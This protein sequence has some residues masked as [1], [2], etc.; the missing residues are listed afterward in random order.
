MPIFNH[1]A[2]CLLFTLFATLP[3]TFDPAADLSFPME[4]KKGRQ[5]SGADLSF[6]LLS[7]TGAVNWMP[8]EALSFEWTALE[9][10]AGAYRIKI[11]EQAP[12]EPAP[13]EVPDT[14]LFF[15]QSG[16]SDTSFIYPAGGAPFSSGS[17]YAWQVET[18][19]LVDG[20]FRKSEN[21]G[22]I[23]FPLS[24]DFT[25]SGIPADTLC[26]GDCFALTAQFG[27]LALEHRVVLYAGHENLAAI[28]VQPAA[29][30]PFP[31]PE[32]DSAPLE[33]PPHYA[34]PASSVSFNI[35]INEGAEGPVH[36]SAYYYQPGFICNINPMDSQCCHDVES[37]EVQ[38]AGIPDLTGLQLEI[39][40]L[41]TG[42]PVA[43]ICSGDPVL[44]SIL[45][46]PTTENTSLVW[47]YNDGN[48]LVWQDIAAAPFSDYTFPAPPGHEVLSIDCEGNTEGFVERAFRAK[49]TF[50]D[51]P[52]FCE[53]YTTEYLLRICCP[54]TNASVEITTEDG[55]D[56]AV[57]L[58]EGD[59]LS[60]DVELLPEDL[61]VSPPGEFV[62]I[63]W[64]LNEVELPDQGGLAAFVLPITA[65]AAGDICLKAVVRNCAGKEKAFTRC[66]NVDPQPVCDT[67]IL[68]APT[69]EPSA[70]EPGLVVYEACPNSAF[71]L[72]ALGFDQSS[73]LMQWEY[74]YD[75]QDWLPL[76]S[77]NAIQNTNLIIEGDFTSIFYRV[78]CDPLS[79]PSGCESCFSSNI[80]EIRE[81][82]PPAEPAFIDCYPLQWCAGDVVAPYVT[83]VEPGVTYTWY[84]NGLALQ[85]NPLILEY[86]LQGNTCFQYTASNE[87][88]TVS[89]NSCCLEV[90][91]ITAAISCPLPPNECACLGDP[92]TL[93]AAG[94]PSGCGGGPLS[95]HWMW[96]DANG[97]PQTANTLSITDIPPANGTTYTLA[98]TD[99]E[100]GCSDT[101]SLSIIPCDKQ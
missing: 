40:S 59:A 65:A 92:I 27:G 15:E 57:G 85:E 20:Q 41:I 50:D 48:S 3:F 18:A 2:L 68:R 62:S 45:N 84:V 44:F 67:I 39:Q 69:L 76:G 36:F 22:V 61:F 82:Q 86:T 101:A 17:Q 13:D 64:F 16:V 49:L 8:G 66:I 24:C 47:Q 38:V 21:V 98:V 83:A 71:T 34:G 58:C 29:G 11:I 14:G 42:I 4:E 54:I 80:I 81:I 1:L 55:F 96:T 46:L 77:S 89:S 33:S 73:C 37:F 5:L 74:S 32:L 12:G 23:S 56:L 94:P 78:K 35:C 60:L 100:L 7:P 79:L 72:E 9:G 25:L 30:P 31:L 70:A 87:C 93:A 43:E 28:T 63:Q 91:E 75:E 51:A 10:Y 26:P 53:Y 88:H 19:E 6:H 90:C 95:Y 99:L 97:T 52:F